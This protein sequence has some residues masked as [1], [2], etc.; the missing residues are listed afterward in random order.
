[1]RDRLLQTT[2]IGL[3]F[4]FAIP[5]IFP[6]AQTFAVTS[7]ST[8]Y[9]IDGGQIAPIYGSS[10]SSSFNIETGGSPISGISS[11]A[12]YQVQQGAPLNPAT[13]VSEEPAEPS[14]GSI[15]GF[16][17]PL[18]LSV[19]VINITNRQAEIIFDTNTGAAKAYIEYGVLGDFNFR[20]IES[21][22]GDRHRFLISNL[23]PGA[24]Y[25]FRI[26][27]EITPNRINVMGPYF[28][29]T[30]PIFSAV[31]NVS[32]LRIT[33]TEKDIS[34]KWLNPLFNDYKRTIVVKKV[35]LYPR[36]A[37]DGTVVF[38][39]VGE[40]YI[41]SEV[42][43]NT[44]YHY[45][46][47]VELI[48]GRVSS[49]V[50]GSIKL[51]EG[52]API[53]LPPLPPGVIPTPETGLEKDIVNIFTLLKQS[54][55]REHY[56]LIKIFG[57]LSQ[58]SQES[59]EQINKI[60]KGLINKLGGFQLDIFESI[61]PT[62][63]KEIEKI[64]Q[65]A[66]PP[67][68]DEEIINTVRPVSLIGT[69]GIDWKILT[70]SDVL[71]KIQRDIFLKGVGKITVS[72][73]DQVYVLKYNEQSDSYETLIRSPQADGI[74]QA[75]IQIIYKDNT[76]EEV[77]RTVLVTP[78]GKA[79]HKERRP[80]SWEKPWQI[81]F[82]DKVAIK[83]AIVTLET[84]NSAGK[85]ATWPS[86]L[87]NQFNPILTNGNGEFAFIVPDGPYRLR[88]ESEGFKSFKSK[89]FEIDQQVV[90]IDA[91]LRH[92]LSTLWIIILI[93]VAIII[94]VTRVVTREKRNKKDEE[95]EET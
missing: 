50:T 32:S 42:V 38:S 77:D 84:L 25:N 6:V 60:R 34:I 94:T 72:I 67:K 70:D 76:F 51:G 41:D 3:L 73:S 57:K 2:V 48:D 88:V 16:L 39:G 69:T 19:R 24:L 83:E 8:N 58:E 4:I 53:K 17:I 30:Q 31:P 93:I 11:S 68:F 78:Y 9:T 46:I 81:L 66:L 44:E 15:G 92:K 23:R 37:F 14:T 26:H 71:L 65:E 90:N 61:T 29:A 5:L 13:Q 10:D 59:I 82:T 52:V 21:E 33:S 22:P 54:V 18:A 64:L 80:W 74:Y 7:N 79:Y 12:N 63:R 20:T 40:F 89:R 45:T 86:Q 95:R 55:A 27:L 35:G 56:E 28:F 91:Q 85:W 47:F 36:S 49:G 62:E 1:M 75:I 87:Y 43:P